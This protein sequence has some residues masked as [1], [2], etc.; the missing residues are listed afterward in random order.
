MR[1]SNPFRQPLFYS[2]RMLENTPVC[3]NGKLVPRA[4][5]GAY[6]GISNQDVYGHSKSCS[7]H[8]FEQL[9]HLH[10]LARSHSAGKCTEVVR[11]MGKEPLAHCCPI[12]ILMTALVVRDQRGVAIK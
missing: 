12:D 9:L 2:T 7:A 5:V 6:P 4:C 10:I 11:C 3:I 8:S 1:N